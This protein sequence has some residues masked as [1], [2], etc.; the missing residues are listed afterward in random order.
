MKLQLVRNAT[1]RLDY[2]GVRFLIDP[3]LAEQGIAPALPG[4]PNQHLSNPT[5][6]LPLP[7][8]ELTQVEAV[9]VTHTH[10][11]HWDDAAQAALPKHLPI[12]TQ[13]AQDQSLIQS[14]GF[15]DVRLI[16]G[17]TFN[18]VSLGQT[19]GQH[20]SDTVMAAVGDLMGQVCGVVFQ[21][22]A[23]K[24]LYIAGDTVWNHYVQDTL[25]Q[26]QPDIVVL[27][28]G[29][30]QITGLGSIIMNKEDVYAVHQ[31]APQA[32]L[33]A[34]HL[35]AVNHAVLTRQQL[36][37]FAQQ[38]GMASQLLVPQDGESYTL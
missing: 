7:V 38:Q 18:G 30:A 34:T 3:F 13:H 37:E 2:A 8:A 29:D 23:E 6:G 21:H 36:K 35:E 25:Q 11:D 22:A 1:L 19:P 5:V 4:T 16:Q 27:N 10:F 14:Q 20:G 15:T 24:T 28:A 33:I 12:F 9:I 26:Y 31:A 17:A 32:T